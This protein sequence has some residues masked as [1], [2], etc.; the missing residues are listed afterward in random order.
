MN[1]SS[2]DCDSVLFFEL[3]GI[4]SFFTTNLLNF[5]MYFF[6]LSQGVHKIDSR[7]TIQSKY[8]SRFIKYEESVLASLQWYINVVF[9][10]ERV[11]RPSDALNVQNHQS[12]HVMIEAKRIFDLCYRADKYTSFM[13]TDHKNLSHMNGCHGKIVCYDSLRQQYNGLIT[14]NNAKQS[15]GNITTLSP[16]VMEPTY[17]F[18]E[19]KNS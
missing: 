5:S 2:N 6:L 7:I 1:V 14:S 12:Q 11:F 19:R 8:W 16:G 4:H 18:W 3:L 17:V 15:E 13:I 9:I 10:R